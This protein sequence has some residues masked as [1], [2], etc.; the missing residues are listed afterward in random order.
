MFRDPQVRI[1]PSHGSS[2][3]DRIAH[4]EGAAAGDILQ[5]RFEVMEEGRLR[6]RRP[7]ALLRQGEGCRGDVLGL[8]PKRLVL[9]VP[10]AAQ[11]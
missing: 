10:K 2:R 7:I 11:K 3:W 6:P 4:R 8:I 1:R 5:S 9:E